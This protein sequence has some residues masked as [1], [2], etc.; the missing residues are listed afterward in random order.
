[1]PLHPVTSYALDAVERH[2]TVGQYERLACLRHLHDLARAGQLP[3]SIRSRVQA[4]TGQE[5]PKRDPSFPWI[6]DEKQSTFV[7]V[8]WFKH[9]RHTE[10]RLVGQPIELCRAS[11]FDIGCIFGWTSREPHPALTRN[12]GRK[13]GI[14]RFRKAMRFVSRKNAKTTEGSGIQLYGMVGDKESNPRCYCA[15]VDRGQAREMYEK[16]KLM[17][18]NSPDVEQR[19]KIRDYKISHKERGGALMPLSKQTKNKDGLNPSFVFVDEYHAHET[20]E[21]YDLISS[22]KGQR[23]QP[24]MFIIT[25]AG[26]D[27][28]S[29]CYAEIEY[30]RKVVSQTVPNERY[31]VMIRELDKDDDEHDPANWVK[32]NPLL[33]STPEGMRELREMHDEAFNSGIPEKINTFRIKNLNR[34]VHG[35]RGDTYMGD[36]MDKWDACAVSRERFAELTKG[37][38]AL[39]GVDLSKTLDLTACAF[40]FALDEERVALTAHGF[41]P[42]DAVKRHE[43]TD[44][45]PYRFYADENWMSLTPGDFVDD[46][47]VAAHID[48]LELDGSIKIHELCY[49]PYNSAR[50]IIDQQEKGRETVE[51]RQQMPSLT[52]A[53]KLFR[54]LVVSGRLIHDGSPL[55]RDHVANAIQIT[56][57]KEN[58]MITKRYAGDTK[59]VDL[60][61]AS[62]TAL[63]RLP[64]LR[65]AISSGSLEGLGF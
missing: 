16:A 53:T 65:E 46:R 9:L 42:E 44:K 49:D 51:V 22:A 60:L 26:N 31:F 48:E 11:V 59:R 36:Y 45:I 17:A 13:V 39:V 24:L 8:D 54:E 27:T 37:M 58:I 61:A 52:A 33:C 63:T 32:S 40:L 41:L 19:L 56:D 38:L 25:T 1:M 10:G 5:V 55:M 12:D 62:I 2:I 18:E 7:A 57:S 6:F 3:A 23:L 64:A 34:W 29:P 14:R 4:A 47:V 21:I 50:F 43:K 20:S 35:A 30:C 15:A 28:E